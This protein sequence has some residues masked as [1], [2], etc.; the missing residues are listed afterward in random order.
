MGSGNSDLKIERIDPLERRS[1]SIS[2][3][4]GLGYSSDDTEVYPV[5]HIRLKLAE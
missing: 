4:L 5:I 2:H 1:T 3:S